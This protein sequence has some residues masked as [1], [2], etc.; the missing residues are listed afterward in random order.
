MSRHV[1]CHDY[2][3]IPIVESKK[4]TQGSMDPQAPSSTLRPS[5]CKFHRSQHFEVYY[6]LSF[7]LSLFIVDNLSDHTSLLS[8]KQHDT[9]PDKCPMTDC[10]NYLNI[11]N[12]IN[13]ERFAGL[14]FCSF[15]Q[16]H[17]IKS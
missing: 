15:H 2:R 11:Q 14:N 7:V 13:R 4:E 8:G 5:D 3:G 12:T 17:P 9:W 6:Y 10:N 1:V 16:I